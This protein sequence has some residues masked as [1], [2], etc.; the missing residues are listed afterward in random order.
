[1]R[2]PI[3]EPKGDGISSHHNLLENAMLRVFVWIVAILSGLVNG[4]VL[5]GR[6][7][8]NESNK[9][10]SFFI[11]NL[12][13]ADLIMGI[14]LFVIASRDV[15][16]R[17]DYLSHEFDWR[18]GWECDACGF[19]SSLSSEVSVLIL[20]VIT[21]DRYMC[22]MY[23]L[24]IKRRSLRSAY[25]IMAFIW[26]LCFMLA[27]LPIISIPYFGEHYYSNN[28][29][30]LP[31]HIHDPFG[32]GW[33]YSAFVYV[34]INFTAFAFVFYSY[35][36]MFYVIRT[37]RLSLRSSQINQ[38]TSLARRFAFIVFSDFFCWVP[39]I[40]IKIIALAG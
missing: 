30:C 27:L 4:V 25:A 31:L 18:S 8:I 15:M 6:F 2:V 21:L 23:P 11:K 1:M 3:C 34:G 9:I 17:G 16:Y 7:L 26:G 40:V 37:S 20:T 12:S 13:M 14:Y 22:V 24:N 33:E 10:H 28:G 29:V 36:A 32:Q 19:L 38:E 35:C 5:L 39:I